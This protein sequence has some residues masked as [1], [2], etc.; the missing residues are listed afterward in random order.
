MKTKWIVGLAVC[1]AAISYGKADGGFDEHF[2]E[3]VVGEP[4]PAPPWEEEYAGGGG[5][6]VYTRQEA[7]N[8]GVTIQVDDSVSWS[9][10]NSV[11]FLDTNSRV[12]SYLWGTFSPISS[13][14]VEYFMR[15][16]NDAYEGAFVA[17]YGD[18]GEGY[19]VAFSNGVFGGSAGWIGVHGSPAGWI[20]PQLLEYA[21]DTWY[22]VRRE[23]DLTTNVGRF[24][25][26]ELVYDLGDSR[27][28]SNEYSLGTNYPNTYLNKIGIWSSWSQRADC[29]IDG[30]VL[31]PEPATL[32]LIAVGVLPILSG[33]KRSRR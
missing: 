23:L 11:H 6:P 18:A 5:S 1:L 14:V 19:N 16:Q 25:V 15:T 28:A 21:E 12:Y 27:N 24:Y 4:P 29:Y 33:L 20:Y 2:D 13:V 9:S 32:M 8:L 3:Y 10:P 26:E 22:Y 30:L 7:A 31:I 17:V